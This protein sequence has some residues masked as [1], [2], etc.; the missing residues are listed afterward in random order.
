MF[1][2]GL[3][4]IVV[5]IFSFSKAGMCR[6]HIHYFKQAKMCQDPKCEFQHGGKVFVSCM[7]V[8]AC[9]ECVLVKIVSFSMS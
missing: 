5:Q 4:C 1:Q 8:S 9:L 6:S 2:H 3:E 7:S